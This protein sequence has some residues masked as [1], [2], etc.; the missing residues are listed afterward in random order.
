MKLDW[1]EMTKKEATAYFKIKLA[2]NDGWAVKGL[3]RIYGN[4]TDDEQ[5]SEQ[6][7]HHNS[8]G[9]TGIDAEL[10]SSFAKFY[11]KHKRLT[12][13]QLVILKK[14]MPKYAGQLYKEVA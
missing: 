6:T 5:S 7:K 14:K 3:L 1:K 8:I 12:E 2:T 4:Q 10:L 11:L 9:F 13:K